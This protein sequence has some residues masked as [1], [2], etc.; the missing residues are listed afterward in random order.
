SATVVLAGA[1]NFASFRDVSGDPARHNV[2][3]MVWAHTMTYDAMRAQHIADYRKLFGRV[4][5]DLGAS[6]SAAAAKPTNERIQAFAA[7]GDPQLA[8]LL[9]QF[10]RYL[11]ISSS[12]PGGQPA[13]LQGLWNESNNPPWESKYTVNINA[14]MNYWPAESTNLGECQ[15]PLFEAMKDLAQSGAVTAREQYNA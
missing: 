6:S 4:T 1:T 7:A 15:W 14:E 11:L 9:F 12:R 3:S 5:L 13:N 2:Q 8:T 10:G